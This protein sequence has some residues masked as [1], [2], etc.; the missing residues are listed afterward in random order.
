MNYIES[1]IEN[2]VGGAGNIVLTQEHLLQ[3]NDEQDEALFFE[4]FYSPKQ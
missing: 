2:K 4:C 1:E 3:I